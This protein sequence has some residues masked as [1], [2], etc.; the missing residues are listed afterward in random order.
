MV[1]AEGQCVWMSHLP[2][3]GLIAQFMSGCIRKLQSPEI[4]A[5][6]RQEAHE[7]QDASA[8]RCLY[9]LG[10]KS[11]RAYTRALRE[12]VDE[13]KMGAS[14]AAPIDGVTL[15]DD[16]THK[17]STK[18]RCMVFCIAEAKRMQFH[19]FLRTAV[20]ATLTQDV[21]NELLLVRMTACD[22]ALNQRSGTVGLVKTAGGGTN[23][24]LATIAAVEQLCTPFAHQPIN[25][26]AS[27]PEIGTA[28]MRHVCAI[29][30]WWYTDAASDELSAGEIF[31][32]STAAR[33]LFPKNQTLWPGKGAHLQTGVGATTESGAILR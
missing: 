17:P 15:G 3:T 7:E 10:F 24:V 19:T 13:Q 22:A 14:F 27:K 9:E 31:M 21:R 2:R 4:E 26:A 29:V 32:S 33:R 23:L 8:E 25:T 12:R 6:E 18:V 5:L 1:V 20:S 11:K 30:T 16:R 28:L